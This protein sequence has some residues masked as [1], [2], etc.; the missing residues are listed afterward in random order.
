[1]A[2][3]LLSFTNYQSRIKKKKIKP[4]SVEMCSESPMQPFLFPTAGTQKEKDETKRDTD[5]NISWVKIDRR[6][7]NSSY[8]ISDQLGDE[9]AQSK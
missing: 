8:K 7:S 5:E 2:E 1:M 4:T 9:F 3:N 6:R